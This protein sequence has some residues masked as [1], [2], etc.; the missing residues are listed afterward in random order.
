MIYLLTF[1]NLLP[2]TFYLYLFRNLL[3]K[4]NLFFQEIITV[5]RFD[6]FDRQ[7]FIYI[8]SSL[9]FTWQSYYKKVKCGKI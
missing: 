8:C 6:N 7:S 9:I 1:D 3:S 5:V 2:L 4:S